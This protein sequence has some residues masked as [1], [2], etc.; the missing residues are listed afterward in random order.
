MMDQKMMMKQMIKFNQT[1]FENAFDTMVRLQ[2]QMETFTAG[3]M[4]QAPWVSSE[5]RQTIDEM[6]NLV[7]SGRTNFKKVVDEGFK[8]M[9]VYLAG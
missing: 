5:N 6:T 4:T 9:E 2:D 1:T 7:K 3:M 8:K